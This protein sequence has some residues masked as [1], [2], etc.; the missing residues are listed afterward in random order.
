MHIE[1]DMKKLEDQIGKINFTDFNV[2]IENTINY[3]L[4]K[5]LS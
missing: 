1:G 3:Y 5:K 2:A 4:N